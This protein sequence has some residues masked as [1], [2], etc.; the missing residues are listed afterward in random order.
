MADCVARL[1]YSL[2]VEDIS[3]S[4]STGNNSTLVL[5][6]GTILGYHERPLEFAAAFRKLRRCGFV[7]EYVSVHTNVTQ[8]AIYIAT[9][10]GRVCRPLII[11]ENGR[12][13][14]TLKH[15]QVRA[16]CVCVCVGGG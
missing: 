9:D 11:V 13:R 4:V 1:A 8:N 15:I 7:S 16:G 14:V 10:G 3:L 12:S 5:L 2:G 6:N